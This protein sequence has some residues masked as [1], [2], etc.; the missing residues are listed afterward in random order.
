MWPEWGSN[1]SSEN[2]NG[3]RANSP[4]HQATGARLK[5]ADQYFAHAFAS[6]WQ[7]PFFTQWNGEIGSRNYFMIN[8]HDSYVAKLSWHLRKLEQ[9]Y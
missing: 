1:N 8:F 7:L 4:I 2:P 5:A 9:M 3:L 6:N